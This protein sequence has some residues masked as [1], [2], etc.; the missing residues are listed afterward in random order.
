MLNVM[1]VFD[2]HIHFSIIK[3]T[4]FVNFFLQAFNK[5]SWW[6]INEEATTENIDPEVFFGPV[7]ENGGQQPWFNEKGENFENIKALNEK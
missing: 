2:D 5:A 3:F 7:F 6:S 1:K 4:Y